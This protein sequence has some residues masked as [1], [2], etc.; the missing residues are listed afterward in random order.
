M[1]TKLHIHQLLENIK[2]GVPKEL[3][4]V[5]D[6]GAFN[7]FYTLGALM[8]LKEME[9][10]NMCK[11]V[12]VSGCSVGSILGVLYLTDSLDL[13]V[14]RFKQIRKCIKQ[15]RN[16]SV[17][18]EQMI[19]LLNDALK[20]KNIELLNN[21]LYINYYNLDEKKNIV[22]DTFTD[23]TFLVD[24]ILK[25]SY[26]P[27]VID[28]NITY[29]DGFIDGINP[30][31][32]KNRTRK[33]LFLKGITFNVGKTL[34]IYNERNAYSRVTEGIIYMHYFF[35]EKKTTIASYIHKWSNCDLFIFRMREIFAVVI[36]YII[37]YSQF[38]SFPG[39]LND[40]HIVNKLKEIIG[41]L[42]DDFLGIF[43]KTE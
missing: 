30:H 35:L 11:I 39:F 9:K 1:S 36:V 33:I 41:Y 10:K 42:L 20:D 13:L 43:L 7:G 3:D 34:S 8:Y 24:T 19:H 37:Y 26:L 14:D 15:N 27:L 29:K 38:V 22:I 25:S 4:L 17:V 16:I 32:F 31:I 21:R 18:Q 28:G 23:V 2:S 5:I 40:L 6:G 12:R